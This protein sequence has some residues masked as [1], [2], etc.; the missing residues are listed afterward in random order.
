A[1]FADPLLAALAANGGPT[2]TH[3]IPAA[4]AARNGGVGGALVPAVDQRNYPRLGTPDRG[5]YE[6]GAEGLLYA[7]GFE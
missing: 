5:A 7:D 3:A 2:P 6:Y 1:Q 4:S